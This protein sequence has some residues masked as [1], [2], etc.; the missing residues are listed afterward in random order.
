VSF[1]TLLVS[2]PRI[3]TV[4]RPVVLER[5]GLRRSYQIP[6]LVAQ[7]LHGSPAQIWVSELPSDGLALLQNSVHI[8]SHH[9][10]VV[11]AVDCASVFAMKMD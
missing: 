1:S 7:A 10:V 3:V 8:H 5:V 2:F 11:I 9:G 4:K 6:Q